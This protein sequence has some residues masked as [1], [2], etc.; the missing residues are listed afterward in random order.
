[1]DVEEFLKTRG[2][3]PAWLAGHDEKPVE[4]KTEQSVQRKDLNT[5]LSELEDIKNEFEKITEKKE[6][7]KNLLRL[8]SRLAYN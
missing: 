2:F 3:S 1:M 5:L 4:N 6:K 7:L 8:Y